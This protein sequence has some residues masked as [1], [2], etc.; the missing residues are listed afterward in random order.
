LP[1]GGARL[2]S[3]PLQPGVALPPGEF[4]NGEGP[5][6]PMPTRAGIP[7]EVA[8]FEIDPT[9]PISASLIAAAEQAANMFSKVCE[10]E[11]NC[12]DASGKE[13]PVVAKVKM[14][15]EHLRSGSFQKEMTVVDMT[16]QEF[17][18]HFIIC[19]K[20]YLIH[21]FHDVMSSQARRNL[22]EKMRT[23]PRLGRVGI[24]AS[25]YAAVFSNH[26]QLQLNQTIQNHSGQLVILFSYLKDGILV[27]VAYSFWNQLGGKL[28]SDNHFYRECVKRVFE[29]TNGLGIELDIIYMLTDG[30]PTQFKN[31][32]NVVFLKYLT[33]QFKFIMIVAVIPPTATFKGEHDAV[34]NLD[35]NII[36]DAE[37][38]QTGRYPSTRDFMQ[39][40]CYAH[41]DITL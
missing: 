39:V 4:W 11:F 24:M 3:D 27:T 36:R 31:R 34:G 41:I 6:P 40:C 15:E 18:E 2:A 25:D 9:D 29:I 23:D 19:T 35:K 5:E 21:H 13:I 30:A 38:G 16:L 22:Y 1:P 37:L 20:K 12:K 32:F 33:R 17:K 26:S 28:K 10:R 8:A 7:A 14:Y